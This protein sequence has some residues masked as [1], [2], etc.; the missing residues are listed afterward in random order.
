M[1]VSKSELT[2]RISDK[3][4]DIKFFADSAMKDLGLREE[5][6]HLL[7]TSPHIMVYYH[8][9]Y[10]LNKASQQHPDLFYQYWDRFASL[11]DHK[12]SYH[13]DI[14]LTLIAN[15]TEVDSSDRFAEIAGRYFSHLG[16]RKF[17]TAQC[18]V[19]SIG[20]ILSHKKGMIDQATDLLLNLDNTC[21]YPQKQKELLKS[22]VIDVL[23]M[24]YPRSPDQAGIDRFVKE[25]LNSTSPK[26][27]K[28]AKEF[29]NQKQQPPIQ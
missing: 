19:R 10:I 13:R 12:N 23:F 28:K 1:K 15:L 8:C 11:L 29:I 2:A 6:V 7:L 27:R 14:G 5:L 24:V 4:V 26:T 25:Q 9:Y 16:D 18:C 21:G 17:M 3:N 22:D 20:K